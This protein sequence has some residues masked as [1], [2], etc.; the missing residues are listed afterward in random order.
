MSEGQTATNQQTGQRVVMRGG[1]WVPLGGPSN[2]PAQTP[3]S[4]YVA[5]IIGEPKPLEPLEI[6]REKRSERDSDL[7]NENTDFDNA[8]TLRDDFER[9]PSVTAYRTSVPMYATAL[10]TQPIP[11]G[12]LTLIKAYAKLTD[13]TTG[14]LNGEGQAVAESSPYFERTVQNLQNQL[15]A[16]GLLSSRARE[17]LRQELRSLMRNRNRAY[18]ADRVTYKKRASARGFDP[19]EIVGP[20]AGIPFQGEESDYIGRP[21]PQLDYNGNPVSDQIETSTR[22]GNDYEG[23]NKIAGR[24]ETSKLIP[25]PPE[26]QG[27]YNAWLDA[28]G[29]GFDPQDYA[30][31]RMQLDRENNYGVDPDTFSRYLEEGK[32]IADPTSNVNR[33]IPGVEAPMSEAEQGVNNLV[34]TP[35]GTVAANY[36]NQAA[37]GAP[38]ALAGQEGYD[39]MSALN[40]RRPVS[41]FAGAMAGGITGAKG[42][43]VGSEAVS[44]ALGFGPEAARMLA[45][46][47]TQNALAGGAVG[48][49]TAPEGQ[50]AQ[51]ALIGAGVAG[52]L[53]KGLNVLAPAVSARAANFVNRRASAK[54]PPANAAEVVAAGQ[55]ENVPVSRPMVDP[56]KRN[57]VI[58]LRSRP[59]G[60][61]VIERG[62]DSTTNAIEARTAALGRGGTARDTDITGEA[63]QKAVERTNKN[64]KARVDG[65]YSQYRKA[66]GDPPVEATNAL[67]AI[68]DEIADLSKAKEPNSEEINYLKKIRSVFA[69]PAPVKTGILDASGKDITRPGQGLTAETLRSM[70]QD[71]RGQLSTFGL[72]QTRADARLTRVFKAAQA[73]L[74]TAM[75]DNPQGLAL[76]KAGNRAHRERKIYV[77]AIVNQ[78]VGKESTGID[79]LAGRID[80][81]VA[82]RKIQSWAKP[83]GKGNSL[84]AAWRS[85]NQSEANDVAATVAANLGRDKAGDFSPALLV[86]QAANLSPKARHIAF[87]PDGAE[88]LGNLIKLSKARSSVPYNTSGS[89]VATNYRN[90]V[91]EAVL[92][93]LTTTAAVVGGGGLSSVLA[94]A[95]V[96]GAV[97]GVKAAG[98]N[99]SARLLMNRDVSRWLASAPKTQ[100][101]A[102]ID[103]HFK[104]L[105]QIA[106]REPV[107]SGEI[108]TLQQRL[109]DAAKGMSGPAPAEDKQNTR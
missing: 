22:V 24:G 56:T 32:R 81:D 72:E 61:G 108:Q 29:R 30:M 9:L 88:S 50:G 14:V 59:G 1:Q 17:G 82:F 34:Q 68:D 6:S 85:L 8:G 102:A 28:H 45:N 16:S 7:N 55:A 21:V 91:V 54:A 98:N 18:I 33:T 37:L 62:L 80:P 15:D 84:A 43:G 65:I 3:P 40:E 86:S 5:P 89:G 52:G 93:G 36:F 41:A 99:I 74:E 58:A 97:S 38:Q 20:H 87:G 12:D 49:T 69:P 79:D 73:D 83:G 75:K 27:K 53:T 26:M 19:E 78:I 70:Q 39:A 76:L 95:G 51:N 92:G 104:R 23:G 77:K 90:F 48:F 44:R 31:M 2:A 64:A 47:V 100:S 106:A 4:R 107:I 63:F 96:A 71:V 35:G 60:A 11:E 101:P 13:P 66:T 10:K 25:I 94:G 42:L 67:K 109:M 103:A 57:D 46:P 105:S